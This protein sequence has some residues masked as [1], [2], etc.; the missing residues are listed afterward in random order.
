MTTG[1]QHY[2]EAER[3]LTASENA[4]RYADDPDRDWYQRQAQAHATLA[5]AAA[6]ALGQ[7]EVRDDTDSYSASIL[8][9]DDYRAWWRI[10]SEGPGERRHRSEAERAE[11]AE[12]APV[13]CTYCGAEVEEQD[14]GLWETG[15]DTADARRYC[16]GAP[17]HLHAGE[18]TTCDRCGGRLIAGEG[19]ARYCG[20][21]TDVPA[22]QLDAEHETGDPRS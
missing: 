14:T 10:A 4:A 6:T 20:P 12:L 1:P 9:S 22:G 21:C 18:A 5:V 3:L 15:E 17:D 16:T 2:A 11:A 8:P 13:H 19:D 7:R